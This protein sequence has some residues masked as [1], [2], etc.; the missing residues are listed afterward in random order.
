MKKR[1]EVCA[2]TTIKRIIKNCSKSKTYRAILLN[3]DKEL[4][5]LS[6][7]YGL[8][9]E[10]ALMLAM[11]LYYSLDDMPLTANSLRKKLKMTYDEMVDMVIIIRKLVSDG[12]IDKT[13]G[14]KD[15]FIYDMSAFLLFETY[16]RKWN[17]RFS[18]IS[19]KGLHYKVPVLGGKAENNNET[20][21]RK[22]VFVGLN[23]TQVIRMTGRHWYKED[24]KIMH[25]FLQEN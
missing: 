21:T 10:E 19:N 12:L 25:L 4:E 20:I 14:D 17:A 24:A 16:S 2:G 6:S 15:E 7:F 11:I 9:N 18:V 1:S 8:T 23:I 13:F 3:S 22:E 5:I